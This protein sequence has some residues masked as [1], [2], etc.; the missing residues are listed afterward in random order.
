MQTGGCKGWER[1]RVLQQPGQE[2]DETPPQVHCLAY[3]FNTE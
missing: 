3:Y 2:E 1:V